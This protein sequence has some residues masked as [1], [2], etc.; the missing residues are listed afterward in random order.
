M[1]AKGHVGGDLAS[2]CRFEMKLKY[3]Q[4]CLFILIKHHLGLCYALDL[5][6]LAPYGYFYAYPQKQHVYD[7]K[8]CTSTLY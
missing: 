3:G 8:G 5:I 4:G 2:M 7:S 1:A 6:I